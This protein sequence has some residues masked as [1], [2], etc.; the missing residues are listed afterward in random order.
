[1]LLIHALIR[2][3]LVGPAAPSRP[4]QRMIFCI[5]ACISK[6]ELSAALS[7]GAAS[8]FRGLAMLTLGKELL[9]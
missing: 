9:H 7:F 2:H 1:M 6:N 4:P 3:L 8:R 5:N